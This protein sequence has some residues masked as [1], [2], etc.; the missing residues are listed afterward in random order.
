MNF[1]ARFTFLMLAAAAAAACSTP[2]AKHGEAK[3]AAKNDGET[4]EAA[5]SAP[6][7]EVEEASLRYKDYVPFPGLSAIPFEYDAAALYDDAR[8]ALKRN[9]KWLTANPNIEI[10]VA[11]HCDDRGTAAYNLA[12]GQKRA[13]A[14]RNYYRMLGVSSGRMATISYGKESPLCSATTD[15][16]RWRNRRAET[17]VRRDGSVAARTP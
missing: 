5:P 11:G 13:N 16:C 1:P 9:S 2:G 8:A 15:S 4:A 17:F 7:A 14:V 3:S 10:R 12:L 6:G